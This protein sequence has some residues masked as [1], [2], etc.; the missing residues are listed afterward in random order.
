[1]W[2]ISITFNIQSVINDYHLIMSS[3]PWCGKKY[4]TKK[5][6]DYPCENYAEID[7]VLKIKLFTR[8]MKYFL[9]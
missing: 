8:M 1:M 3:K 6:H 7:N 5:S 2:M 9:Y 4:L